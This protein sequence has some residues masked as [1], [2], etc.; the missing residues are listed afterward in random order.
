V[1]DAYY[2]GHT[3]Q[4]ARFKINVTTVLTQSSAPTFA[5]EYYN[6]A[7]VAVSGLV[8]GTNGYET[9]GENII[10]F[11]LPGDWTTVTVNSQGPFYYVRIRLTATGTITQVPIGQTAT[12]DVTRYIPY[13]EKRIIT[14]TGL[15]DI[16]S[17][18]EDT[19]SNFTQ[20]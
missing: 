14:S 17:W 19:I 20:V 18:Q 5:V 11:T 12:L 1:N 7:W 2:F 9:S 8:D 6:G 4:F 13:A 10:S 15:A 16:A 3:E